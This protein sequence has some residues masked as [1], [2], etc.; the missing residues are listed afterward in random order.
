MTTYDLNTLKPL[1]IDQYDR[2]KATALQRVTAHIGDKPTRAQ[3]KREFGRLW[4]VLDVLAV[5]V[6]LAALAVS[7]L[8]ILTWAGKEAATIYDESGM[9]GWTVDSQ[10]FAR[11]HQAGLIALSEASILLFTVMARLYKTRVRWVLLALAMGAAVFVFAA[12]L[13]SGIHSYVAVLIPSFTVGISLRLEAL[14]VETM[15]QRREVDDKYKAAL[16]VWEQSSHD[17]TKHPDYMPMLRRELWEKLVSLKANKDFADAPPAF[18][19]AAVGRELARELWAYEE[20]TTPAMPDVPA[21]PAVPVQN[22]HTAPVQNGVSASAAPVPLATNGHTS[23]ST[24]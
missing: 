9:S 13:A 2:A 6:F 18:K 22:G 3:Y 5:I 19:G 11:V 12:N 15:K 14:L 24:N 20:H 4:T 23:S 21:A 16:L 1:T 17:A 10:T 8:H 7:S